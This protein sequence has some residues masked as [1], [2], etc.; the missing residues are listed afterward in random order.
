MGGYHQFSGIMYIEGAL[1]WIGIMDMDMDF[2]IELQLNFDL[3]LGC[4]CDWDTDFIRTGL[5]TGQSKSNLFLG[6]IFIFMQRRTVRTRRMYVLID[7]RKSLQGSGRT[8]RDKG[9]GGMKRHARAEE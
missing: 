8:R 6:R 3:D 9:W 5:E 7:R 2:G 4:N 1:I